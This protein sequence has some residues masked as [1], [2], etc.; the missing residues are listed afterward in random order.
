MKGLISIDFFYCSLQKKYQA[1]PDSYNGAVHDNY[2]WSQ[3]IT[4]AEAFANVRTH[5]ERKLTQITNIL[6]C[7]RI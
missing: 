3:S 4:D 1:N 2:S 5:F 6:Q 7:K